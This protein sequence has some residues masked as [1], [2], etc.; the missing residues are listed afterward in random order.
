[1]SV[2]VYINS[3]VGVY[4]DLVCAFIMLPAVRAGRAT[5]L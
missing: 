1:M 4:C 5:G 2:S 3:S